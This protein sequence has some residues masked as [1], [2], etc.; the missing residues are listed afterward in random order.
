MHNRSFPLLV[1]FGF[2]LSFATAQ[3]TAFMSH[4]TGSF[5]TRG[6]M[7]Q[8]VTVVPDSGTDQLTG[9]AGKM[10]IIVENG[11]HNYRLDYTL[12]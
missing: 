11:V 4:A 3:E 5:E 7:E 10:T 8:M 6:A 1:A 2:F 12:P 9:L